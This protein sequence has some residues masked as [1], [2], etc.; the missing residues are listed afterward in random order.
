MKRMRND[1]NIANLRKPDQLWLEIESARYL[2][3]QSAGHEGQAKWV[4]PIMELLQE[5][6]HQLGSLAVEALLQ[7]GGTLAMER[8]KQLSWTKEGLVVE[9][10]HHVGAGRL[11]PL[12]GLVEAAVWDI[13]SMLTRTYIPELSRPPPSL[14]HLHPHG[15]F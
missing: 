13:R 11:S 12:L 3:V 9:E 6:V 5:A 4:R 2:P 1:L 7:R 8:P 14:S 15:Y 10:G